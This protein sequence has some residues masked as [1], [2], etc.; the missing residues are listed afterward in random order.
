MSSTKADNSANTSGREAPSSASLAQQKR[1]IEASSITQLISSGLGGVGFVDPGSNFFGVDVHPAPGVRTDFVAPWDLEGSNLQM[2]KEIVGAVVKRLN[3]GLLHDLKDGTKSEAQVLE[4]LRSLFA[5]A[6]TGYWTRIY[7]TLARVSTI[8]NTGDLNT[9]LNEI[10]TD[11]GVPK[12][13][14]SDLGSRIND[15]TEPI[16][17]LATTTIDN[18]ERVEDVIVAKTPD[19]IDTADAAVEEVAKQA[20]PITIGLAVVAVAG[21]YFFLRR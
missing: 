5:A 7:G 12:T 2:R 9:F 11:A 15:L 1:E 10:S 18:V 13:F 6:D 8:Q 4:D 21:L 20:A 19:I 14:W 3:G 17:K 16:G